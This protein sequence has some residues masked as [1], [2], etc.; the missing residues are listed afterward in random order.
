M[1]ELSS[2]YKKSFFGKRYKLNWRAEHLC[3]AVQKTANLKKN[4]YIIDVG[5][6]TGEFINEFR[7]RGILAYGFEGSTEAFEFIPDEIKDYVY[8][9]DLRKPIKRGIK[10]KIALCLEVAEHIEAEYAD[11]FV[12]NLTNLSNYIII[13]AAPPGQKGH[14]HVNCKPP[15]YWEMLFGKFNYIRQ[16][17]D[18]LI[19]K[20]MLEQ[21][22]RKKGLNAYYAN[23][24]IFKVDHLIN[25]TNF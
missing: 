4:D 17:G 23:T 11:I 12:K 1:K 14:F 9:K 3:N 16:K 22:K 25:N 5:C 2:I 6:A 20:N 24:L 7:N 21:F 10:F 19:F 18:E 13:S 8:L 15:E